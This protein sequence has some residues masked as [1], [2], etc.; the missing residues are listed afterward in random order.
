MLSRRRPDDQSPQ[1][2]R[3]LT[4]LGDSLVLHVQLR[5]FDFGQRLL[6][7]LQAPVHPGDEDTGYDELSSRRLSCLERFLD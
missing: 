1:T 5:L 6:Q 2:P 7:D 4:E 3:G